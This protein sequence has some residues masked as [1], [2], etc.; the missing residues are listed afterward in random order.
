MTTLMFNKSCNMCT[1]SSFVPAFQLIW[2]EITLAVKNFIQSSASIN[3][4]TRWQHWCS[5]NFP[6]TFA[7]LPDTITHINF[8]ANLRFHRFHLIFV[9]KSMLTFALSLFLHND[10]RWWC[11]LPCGPRTMRIES[12][13]QFHIT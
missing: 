9:L 8:Y 3:V 4:V 10:N 11:T 12:N 13:S 6:C 5:E 1:K 7:F 2:V